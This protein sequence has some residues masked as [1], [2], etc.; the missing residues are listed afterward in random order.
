MRLLEAMRWLVVARFGSLMVRLKVALHRR[1]FGRLLQPRVLGWD[2]G[3]SYVT[4]W[5][6]STYAEDSCDS[7]VLSYDRCNTQLRVD[8]LSLLLLVLFAY[9]L[10]VG[11]IPHEAWLRG[12][13][14]HSPLR[15]PLFILQ[16]YPLRSDRLTFVWASTPLDERWLRHR[17]VL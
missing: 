15:V 16:M 7:G 12:S 5:V 14:L 3:S 8:P 11:H 6:C 9:I 2:A 17:D 10:R 4:H 13:F 1:H